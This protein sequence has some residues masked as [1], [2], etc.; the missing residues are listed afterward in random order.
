[1]RNHDLKKFY[2]GVYQ[3]GE[4]GHYS[5]LLFGGKITE[6]KRE[7]LKSMNWKG[8]RVLDVG[9]GT[10]EL[11]FLIGSRGAKE[12]IGIDY[13]YSAI[14]IA[15]QSYKLPELVYKCM[16]V[17]NVTGQFDVIT[18]VGILEHIDKPEELLIKA[19]RLLK[20]G[21]SIIV[22]CPNW[23]NPRG[24]ILQTLRHLFSAKITL[25][26][27]HYFTPIFFQKMAAKTGMKLSWKTIEQ[28][29]GHG[30]K[31]IK[32]FRKRLP[33]VLKDIACAGKDKNISDFID[34]LDHMALPL[35]KNQ[36]WSGATGF[37]HFKKM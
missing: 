31:M 25:V 24:Y 2:D 1:M 32:D 8:K 13:S 9:C 4:K 35:E 12:V 6:E 10:G 30:G 28:D 14:H 22:T 5:K 33:N 11:A 18:L 20:K 36:K 19:K 23:S 15:K 17:R 34:W 37:Y 29:W 26:D 27:I 16:D 3:R 21:G 7:I